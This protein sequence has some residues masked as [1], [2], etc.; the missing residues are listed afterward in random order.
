MFHTFWAKTNLWLFTYRQPFFGKYLKSLLAQQQRTTQTHTGGTGR[1]LYLLLLLLPPAGGAVLTVIGCRWWICKTKS[2]KNKSTKWEQWKC[3]CWLFPPEFLSGLAA[4]LWRTAAPPKLPNVSSGLKRSP[5]FQLKL[6]AYSYLSALLKSGFALSEIP[7]S[8]DSQNA[9][10]KSD[11]LKAQK[12]WNMG[13]L[14]S[15]KS[16]PYPL[17]RLYTEVSVNTPLILMVP[18]TFS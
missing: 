18:F 14:I 10:H 16:A 7:N 8:F 12:G 9:Y 13:S 2:T 5:G 6:S 11:K 3:L 4:S 1:S 17:V 15:P